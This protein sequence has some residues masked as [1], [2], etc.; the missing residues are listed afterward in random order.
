MCIRKRVR[1]TRILIHTS[2]GILT[3][4][5]LKSNNIL[6]RV[7][8]RRLEICIKRWMRS[9]SRS[10][11][12]LNTLRIFKLIKNSRWFERK[13]CH[14]TPIMILKTLS[15]RNCKDKYHIFTGSPKRQRTMESRI[16]TIKAPVLWKE[17][18]IC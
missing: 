11:K 3:W 15:H 4:F 7:M 16:L 10:I 9:W 2:L 1:S 14:P 5:K 17:H 13:L 18:K 6:K 8:L 12:E